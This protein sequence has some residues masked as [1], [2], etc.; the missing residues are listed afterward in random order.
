M[1]RW[2]CNWYP[3][4]KPERTV[5][6]RLLELYHDDFSELSGADI[7]QHGGL[8]PA[9]TSAGIMSINSSLK[10]PKRARHRRDVELDED[11]LPML[12]ELLH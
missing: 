10:E 6:R 2:R 12:Q 4:G 1:A 7:G 9:P 11:T 5:L 3:T 8:A